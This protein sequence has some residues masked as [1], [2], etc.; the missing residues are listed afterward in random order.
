MSQVQYLKYVTFTVLKRVIVQYFQH[1]TGTVLWIYD[2]YFILNLSQ[3]GTQN[4]SQVQYFE[5]VTDTVLL[6]RHIY[7]QRCFC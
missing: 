5:F 6:T 7:F 3:H 4:L 2:T 1:V